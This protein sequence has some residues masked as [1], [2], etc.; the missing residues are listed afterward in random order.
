MQVGGGEAHKIG[1]GTVVFVNPQDGTVAAVAGE[2]GEAKIAAAA[3]DV[4][5][6]DDA[7]AD[8]IGIRGF[9]DIGDK[10]MAE[11]AAKAHVAFGDF[12]IGGADPG[13]AHAKEGVSV[14]Q[15]RVGLPGAVRQRLIVD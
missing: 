1:E 11:D 10:F 4:D 14:R 9:D 6:A 3:N 7:L 13:L 5:L 8:E 2:P 15:G 12:Q